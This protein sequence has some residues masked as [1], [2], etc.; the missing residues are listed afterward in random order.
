MAIDLSKFLKTYLEESFE[1]LDQAE[2]SL[3]AL[4]PSAPDSEEIHSI[5]RAIHSIKGGAGTFG[6][7]AIGGLAHSMETL[8][9][10]MRSEQRPVDQG[11]V[12]LLLEGVD[13]AR[14]LL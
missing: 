6:L 12:N 7:S 5:F 3:L 13:C 4:E 11:A 14:E 8:L 2:S 1:G 9:D 10:E